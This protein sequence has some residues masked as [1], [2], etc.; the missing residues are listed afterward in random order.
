MSSGTQIEYVDATGAASWST[1]TDTSL[2][3]VGGNMYQVTA[4]VKATMSNSI[5]DVVSGASLNLTGSSDYVILESGS[6]SSMVTG[7][8]NT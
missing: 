3:H 1:L 5:L 4:G 8:N 7:D 6:G 2:V